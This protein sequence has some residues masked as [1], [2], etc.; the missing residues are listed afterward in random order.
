MHVISESRPNTVM[1][2]GIPAAG[3]RP[4][5]TRPAPR[6]RSAARSATE[7]ENEW[8]SSSQ[9]ARICGTRSSHAESDSR[10]RPR[11]SPNRRSTVRFGT[12]SSPSSD[13]TTSTRTYHVSRGASS[14]SH[15]IPDAVGSP[16]SERISCVRSTSSPNGSSNRNWFCSSSKY[17]ATT[18][19]SGAARTGSPSAKSCSL[20]EMM[21][22]KSVARS[23]PSSNATGAIDWFWIT[24]WS[25][26]PSPTKRSRLIERTSWA[27]PPASGFR[28]K[29]AA[30]KYSTL[31][32]ERSSG[33]APLIVSFSRD[34]KRVSSANRPLVSPSRS[35]ISSQMQ[36]VDPSRIVSAIT[37]RARLWRRST[38]RAP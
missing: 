24:T 15:E 19:G 8:P 4:E 2:H 32:D 1:N 10:T 7:C 25:C 26:I 16:G 33:F 6:I 11:S 31:P 14:M 20:T 18:G 17:G 22:A 34:R 21:S 38:G 13:I 9:L 36:K 12:S 35:P 29:N 23:R 30:E 5:P 28:R 3:S 27:S 37:A